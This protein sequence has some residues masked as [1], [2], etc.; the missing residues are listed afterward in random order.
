M[1]SYFWLMIYFLLLLS[2]ARSSND[3][4][5][6]MTNLVNPLCMDD[7]EIKQ[8]VSYSRS[9]KLTLNSNEFSLNSRSPS[10]TKDSC[11]TRIDSISIS[12]L[13]KNSKCKI[14]KL[15]IYLVILCNYTKDKRKL[16]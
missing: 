2:L 11:D 5:L 3:L 7:N 13:M 10:D 9:T 16:V 4:F 6:N 8:L 12:L 15:N 1:I 14:K